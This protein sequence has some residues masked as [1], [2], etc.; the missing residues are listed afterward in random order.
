MYPSQNSSFTFFS[1]SNYFFKIILVVKGVDIHMEKFNFEK[2]KSYQSFNSLDEMNEVVR[3]FLYVHKSSLT[4]GAIQVFRYIVRHSCKIIGV[5]FSKNETI[6]NALSLG[7]RT[8]TRS[9][10]KLQELNILKKIHTLRENGKQGANILVIQ[11]FFESKM[12]TYRD[13][14]CDHP[15]KAKK[16]LN[17]LCEKH[18]PFIDK[19]ET[20]NIAPPSHSFSSL[21]ENKILKKDSVVDIDSSYL[22]EFIHPEF[23]KVADPFFSAIE[24]FTLWKRVN[25]AYNKTGLNRPLEEMMDT[26]VRSL[27][28]TIFMHKNKKIHTSFAGY[29]YNTLY[30]NLIAVKRK[31][32]YEKFMFDVF[33]EMVE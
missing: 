6:A 24:I 10:K 7:V 11:P 14:V 30:R 15:N 21:L 28:I 8:V 16:K 26:V 2:L 20:A 18:I 5:S 13:H 27:K 22:P 29:F 17:S 12:T 3:R 32:N 1:Y 33:E 19:E 9:I 23:I 31:E 25:I 4:N